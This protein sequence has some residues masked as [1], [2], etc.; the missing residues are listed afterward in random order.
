MCAELIKKGCSSEP[1]I[2]R[3]NGPTVRVK[4]T[5]GDSSL[6]SELPVFRP[7]TLG[8]PKAHNHSPAWLGRWP[9]VRV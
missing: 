1:E 3:T 5:G 4:F 6:S 8:S 2:K 9:A 7:L